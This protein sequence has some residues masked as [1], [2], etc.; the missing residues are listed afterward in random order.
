MASK[1]SLKEVRERERACVQEGQTG[2]EME[3]ER[4]FSRVHNE[5]AAQLG[6]Q[7][8]HPEIMT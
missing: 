4:L 8:H 6:A 7:S 2:K 5:C 1:I 3:K